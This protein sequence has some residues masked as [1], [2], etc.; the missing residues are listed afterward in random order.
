MSSPSQSPVPRGR[1]TTPSN[2]A[3]TPSSA[4]WTRLC[5]PPRASPELPPVRP[6]SRIL[7]PSEEV[8]SVQRLYKTNAERHENALRRAEEKAYHKDKSWPADRT[9]SPDDTA[10]AVDRLYRQRMET[11][12]A[13]AKALRAKYLAKTNITMKRF[14]D[15]SEAAAALERL[16]GDRQQERER[17]D[18]LFRRHNPQRT[19]V[20]RSPDLIAGNVN[21]YFEG[22]FAKK[23]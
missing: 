5:T 7:K 4:V 2:R 13:Q 19:R 12:D 11:R 23:Q 10:Q 16:N 21:R 22:G 17:Y 18:E 15:S 6:P 3:D 14:A 9:M 20:T 1:S 8:E